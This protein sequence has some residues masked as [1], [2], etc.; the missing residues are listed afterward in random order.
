VARFEA[1]LKRDLETGA[2]AA[3][4]GQMRNE[5]FFDGSL[6]LIVGRR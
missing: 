4:Y 2:W 6:K 1:D 5:P 3:R